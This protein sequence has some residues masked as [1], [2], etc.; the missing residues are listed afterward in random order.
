MVTSSFRFLVYLN[1]PFHSSWKTIHI[2]LFLLR[3]SHM[4]NSRFHKKSTFLWILDHY[5]RAVL[6][7][8]VFCNDEFSIVV[9]FWSPILS[10]SSSILYHIL[11]RYS[12]MC[13]AH[14]FYSLVFLFCWEITL[15]QS[16]SSLKCFPWAVNQSLLTSKIQVILS[17]KILLPN[18]SD[19]SSFHL[20]SP[21]IHYFLWS[22]Y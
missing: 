16:L 20:P 13:I 9:I 14:L 1:F 4:R 21:Q 7:G 3:I 12:T 11:H 6:H 10:F 2:I 5:G 17:V 8:Y 15:F 19:T 18:N 22:S